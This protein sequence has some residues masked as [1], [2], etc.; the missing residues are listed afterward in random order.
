[1][2]TPLTMDEKVEK[3]MNEL[4]AKNITLTN[5]LKTTRYDLDTYIS[6]YERSVVENKALSD[7]INKKQGDIDK[8]SS[9]AIKYNEVKE[10]LEIVLKNESNKFDSFLSKLDEKPTKNIDEYKLTE[11]EKKIIEKNSIKNKGDNNVLV[12]SKDDRIYN[13]KLRIYVM[14][15][16]GSKLSNK[17]PA[18][19]W[20]K[21]TKADLDK[22]II[23]ETQ[24]DNYEKTFDSMNSNI[25]NLASALSKREAV[26]INIIM[27]EVNR[28]FTYDKK[29]VK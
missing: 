10:L 2:P 16:L 17:T 11:A 22:I 27:S 29:N 19:V 3:K 15:Q 4:I 21:P 18:L 7:I 14:Q 12:T 9:Y 24:L 13:L 23:S 6:M 8:L 20:Q 5:E 25:K 1:M 26:D 28:I